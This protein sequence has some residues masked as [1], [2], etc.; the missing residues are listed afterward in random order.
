VPLTFQDEA[1]YDRLAAG[2][3]VEI[4]DIRGRLQRGEELVL[5]DK[6]KGITI[7]LAYN[8]SD[9]QRDILLAGGTLNYVVA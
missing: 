7:P 6:T 5:V 4:P 3:A 2:D 9:R 1:D 8:F